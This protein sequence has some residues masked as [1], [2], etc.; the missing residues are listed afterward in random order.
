LQKKIINSSRAKI[1]V[2]GQGK[3]T[4]KIEI[5]AD[6][7]SKSAKDAIIKAGGKVEV[8]IKNKNDK[9]VKAIK[10]KTARGKKVSN[11]K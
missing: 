7:F 11:K 8:K 10:D 2:L 4:K 5:I 1:K 9:P 6:A 3:L